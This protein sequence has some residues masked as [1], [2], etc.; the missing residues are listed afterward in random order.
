M[1]QD[2][3]MASLLAPATPWLAGQRLS[4]SSI[5]SLVAPSTPPVEEPSR[6]GPVSQGG[7]HTMTVHQVKAATSELQLHDLL[8]GADNSGDWK[9]GLT[10]LVLAASC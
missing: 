8:L 4:A 6:G 10:S 2:S 7:D 1:T 3:T 9:L 5:S